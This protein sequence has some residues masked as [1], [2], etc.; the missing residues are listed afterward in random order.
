MAL[1]RRYSATFSQSWE[2]VRECP[3]YPHVPVGEGL[4]RSRGDNANIVPGNPGGHKNLPYDVVVI[5]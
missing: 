5:E 2:R 4:V 3:I 1:T